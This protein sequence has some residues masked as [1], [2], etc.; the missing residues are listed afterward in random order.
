MFCFAALPD[1]QKGKLYIDATGVLPA[2]LLVEHQ[3]FFVAYNCVTHSIFAEPISNVAYASIVDAFDDVF[4]ELT[5]NSFKPR[6]K[7]KDNQATGPLKSYMAKHACKWNFVESSNH[8]VNA[9]EC[10][11]Q[12]FKNHF[13]GGLCSTDANWLVQL[14]DHLETGSNHYQPTKCVMN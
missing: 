6:F 3:Y 9:A 11:T 10:A 4:T 2:I 8:L 1:K 7:V 13:I 5:E 12:T 14:W